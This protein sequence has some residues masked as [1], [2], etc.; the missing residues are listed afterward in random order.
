MSHKGATYTNGK[1]LSSDTNFEVSLWSV[2]SVLL[3]YPVLLAARLLADRPF[4][5]QQ[6]DVSDSHCMCFLLSHR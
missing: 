4:G 1:S 3:D 5:W 6:G 2:L